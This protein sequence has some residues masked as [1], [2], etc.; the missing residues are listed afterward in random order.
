M[1]Y[2]DERVEGKKE[3]E[4]GDFIFADGDL[5]V[6]WEGREDG[7]PVFKTIYVTGTEPFLGCGL[8]E[9][10]I[11]ELVKYYKESYDDF[12]LIKSEELKIVREKV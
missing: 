3:A 2:I 6:I 1:K 7:K 9:T 10:S 4:V 8:G 5:R 11:D 12:E